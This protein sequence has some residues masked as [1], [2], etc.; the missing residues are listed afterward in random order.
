[1]FST[2][3][4]CRDNIAQI[5]LALYNHHNGRGGPV[6]GQNKQG[7]WIRLR[8]AHIERSLPYGVPEDALPDFVL[9]AVEVRE[10]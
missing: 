9:R 7:D 10:S 6:Y 5:K 3:E 1:M 4:E 8:T 2:L